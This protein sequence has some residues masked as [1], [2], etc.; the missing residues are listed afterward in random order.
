MQLPRLPSPVSAP[1]HRFNIED[2]KMP[3]PPSA[4]E[5]GTAAVPIYPFN[6]MGLPNPVERE[7]DSARA[8]V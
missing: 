3:Q 8:P 4:I 5:P 6:S 1:D 7:P 2:A